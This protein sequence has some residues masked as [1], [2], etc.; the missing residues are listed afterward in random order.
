M[1]FPSQRGFSFLFPRPWSTSHPPR[2]PPFPFP[3]CPV[4]SLLCYQGRRW[5]CREEVMGR[6]RSLS[7]SDCRQGQPTRLPLVSKEERAEWL[8]M[9]TFLQS[10]R[11]YYFWLNVLEWADQ[12]GEQIS[13]SYFS[14]IMIVSTGVQHLPWV[15]KE[16][17]KENLFSWKFKMTACRI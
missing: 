16:H 1:T 4:C 12:E 15:K 11:R 3:L 10:W 9:R 17:D 8:G 6:K 2:S 14:P 13:F 7:H 5:V